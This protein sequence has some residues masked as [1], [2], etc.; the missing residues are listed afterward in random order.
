MPRTQTI[1]NARAAE[2]WSQVAPSWLEFEHELETIS[3]WPGQLA[4]N[5]LDLEPGHTVVDLGCGSGLTTVQLA[6]RVGEAGS[7]LGVD[8][9]A[10]LL[11]EA[12]RRADR[13]GAGNVEFLAADIQTDH[14]GAARFDRAYSRFGLMFCADPPAAFA[15]L[16]HALRPGG[17]LSFV[18]FQG[19]AENEWMLVPTAAALAATGA[20]PAAPDPQQPD[21]FS[22]ADADHLRS[23]LAAAGFHDIDIHAHNDAVVTRAPDIPRIVAARTHIGPVAELLRTADADTTAR[24]HEA[25]TAALRAR[26]HEDLLRLTRG[27]LL[28]AATA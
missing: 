13:H 8:L 15:N 2:Y 1:A 21:L 7:A 17:R 3:E 24:V 25:I 11:G 9:S 23:I 5:R 19:A 22:L 28:V 20:A 10:E 6:E 4:M 26:L 12:R 18:C 27:T 14:L 16:R